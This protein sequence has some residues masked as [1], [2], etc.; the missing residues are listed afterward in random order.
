MQ[1]S[2]QLEP[3]DYEMNQ[4]LFCKLIYFASFEFVNYN[5]LD[6][7]TLCGTDTAR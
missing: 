1:R 7:Q 6:L 4:I 3:V 2:A 5:S